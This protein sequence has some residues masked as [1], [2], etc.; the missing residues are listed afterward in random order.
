MLSAGKEN[1]RE[2]SERESFL[3]L[4]NP[5]KKAAGSTHIE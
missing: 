3:Q 4:S 5:A 1:K 2:T